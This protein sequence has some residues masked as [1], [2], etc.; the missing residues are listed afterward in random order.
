MA[1]K[2]SD[3]FPWDDGAFD[4]KYYCYSDLLGDAALK[5]GDSIQ[6]LLP[7]ESGAF[8]YSRASNVAME[9]ATSSSGGSMNSASKG[10]ELGVKRSLKNLE[11]AECHS[12]AQEDSGDNSKQPFTCSSKRSR[13]AE[14]H[15]LSEKRRRHRINEKMKALQNLIPNSNKTDKASMLDEAIDYL[16]KLQLQVQILSARSGIDISSMCML[17]EMQQLQIPQIPKT[18]MNTGSA[19]VS[20]GLDRTI[21][22]ANM[23]QG[24]ARSP[25]LSSPDTHPESLHNMAMPNLSSAGFDVHTCMQ[26][27]SKMN[28]LT[29]SVLPQVPS[30]SQEIHSAFFLQHH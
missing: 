13:A 7:S 25:L 14:V 24:P 27:S 3:R 4:N 16:K 10:A 21:G 26:D 28:Q 11:D 18:Y 17:S 6:G 20:L 15:N 12:E 5:S 19:G 30:S 22:L 29:N 9:A 2:E 23:T 1:E 8:G